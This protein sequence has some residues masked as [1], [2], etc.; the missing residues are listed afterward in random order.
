MVATVCVARMLITLILLLIN[1]FVFSAVITIALLIVMFLLSFRLYDR[2]NRCFVY[3]FG[4][5]DRLD[6]C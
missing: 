5:M 2:M 4:H 6:V 3:S 1:T